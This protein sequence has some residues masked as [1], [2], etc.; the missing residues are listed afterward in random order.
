MLYDS[1]Q[2]KLMALPDPVRVFPAHGAG[3]SCGKNLSTERQSTIGVQRAFNY[4]CQPMTEAQFL[5]VVTAG[6]PPAPAYFV[7]NATLNKQVRHVRDAHTTVPALTDEQVA[8]ALAD[9]AVLQD[10]RD[11]QEFS[12]GHVRGAL[13]VPWDGRLAETVGTV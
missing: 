10:A 6:Q 7:Y 8:A 2:H 9:G 1:V 11:Q 4:A 13:N 5:E 12:A 3:S